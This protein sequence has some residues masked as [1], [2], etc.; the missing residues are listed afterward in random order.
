MRST[1]VWRHFDLWLM[2][3]VLLLTAYGILAI[4]SAVTGAPAFETYPQRQILFAVAGVVIM[5]LIAAI[6]Y[7][8]LTS[9]HWY[10]YAVFIASLIFVAVVGVIN[11]ESR[12][13]ISLG[14]IQIQPS[15]FGR[16]FIAITFAQFL[17]GCADFCGLGA[18]GSNQ[19]QNANQ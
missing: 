16:V 11:N 9:S 13:W 8:V 7:R 1:S 5:L 3:A 4:K 6:D 10:I 12:R 19:Q 2:A 15:E 18:A 14:F 17:V